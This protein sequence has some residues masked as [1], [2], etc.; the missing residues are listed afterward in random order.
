VSER[1]ETVGILI[2][3][4]SRLRASPQQPR[5]SSL[6][7]IPQQKRNPHARPARRIPRR[8]SPKS[9]RRRPRLEIQRPRTPSSLSS[10]PFARLDFN[11]ALTRECNA[12][13]EN[14]PK[15][16]ATIK[17]QEGGKAGELSSEAK[18]I[19][20]PRASRRLFHDCAR[21]STLRFY[22]FSVFR[23]G[24]VERALPPRRQFN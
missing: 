9:P 18:G 20:C 22:A 15:S 14:I 7:V 17:E 16:P 19:A 4:G 21:R 12:L 2:T 5:H 11:T 1:R 13:A 10:N 6:T 23:A 3:L 24:I 8:V